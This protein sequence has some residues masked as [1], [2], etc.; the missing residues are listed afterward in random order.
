M[1][2]LN[3]RKSERDSYK[4]RSAM[5]VIIAKKTQTKKTETFS[6]QYHM[7]LEI[8]KDNSY[9]MK[10]QGQKIDLCNEGEEKNSEIEKV[11]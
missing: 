3:K 8:G 5:D 9:E 4:R 7:K 2:I 1:V 11:D 10:A 6:T